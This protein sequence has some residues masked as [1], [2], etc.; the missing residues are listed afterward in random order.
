VGKLLEKILKILE[1]QNILH[2]G[3][4]DLALERRE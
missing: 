4:L 1:T 3:S 2:T